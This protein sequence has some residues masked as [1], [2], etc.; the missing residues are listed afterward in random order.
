MIYKSAIRWDSEK[1]TAIWCGTTSLRVIP[2]TANLM[3]SS[4]CIVV[5]SLCVWRADT[6]PAWL[7]N[8]NLRTRN[9]RT[10]QHSGWHKSGGQGVAKRKQL[11]DEGG[12]G[13]VRNG[14]GELDDDKVLIVAQLLDLHA[15]LCHHVQLLQC[16][17]LLRVSDG[18][19]HIWFKSQ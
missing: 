18:S 8:T 1:W 2:N 19:D 16:V 3:T 11:T 6:S 5:H 12:Q 4:C 17:G 9:K 13:A 15:F 10:K 14:R 7:V